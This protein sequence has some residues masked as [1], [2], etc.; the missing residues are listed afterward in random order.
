MGVGSEGG[1]SKGTGTRGSEVTSTLSKPLLL[2]FE[3]PLPL[4][5]LMCVL[6]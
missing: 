3:V 1:T 2:S 6:V 5:V 4:L